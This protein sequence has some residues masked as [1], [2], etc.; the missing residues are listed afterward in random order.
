M[1]AITFAICAA[2][3]LVS[4]AGYSAAGSLRHELTPEE[5]LIYMQQVRGRDWAAMN[6]QQRCARRQQM[7]AQFASM[8]PADLQKLKQE[9]DSRWQKMPTAERQRIEQR[10]ADRRAHPAERSGRAHRS[11]CAETST[12]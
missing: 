11:P 8:S 12:P 5:R 2:T 1:K 3:V 7:R 10:I 6:L 9:L 4:A